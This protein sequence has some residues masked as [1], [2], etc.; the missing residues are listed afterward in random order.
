ML[1]CTPFLL[2][3][4]NCAEAMTFYHK[5]LGG[6]LTLTRLGDTPMK[7]Q[8]P[9][10]KHNRIINAYLKSGSIEFSATDWMASPTFE[11]KQGNTFAIFVI[12]TAY[13]ELKPVFDNLS[14]GAEKER[15]QELHDM[16]FGKYGQFYDKYGIQWI[17]KGDK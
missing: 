11:P 6:E 10:E 14:E 4:G 7:A 2:F 8:F 3:D 1:K 13:E 5:C 15:F 16:P 12:G 17:F 9:P